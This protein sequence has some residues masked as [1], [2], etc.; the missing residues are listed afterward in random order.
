M[1][2]PSLSTLAP[3]LILTIY[4]ML[5]EPS[6]ITALNS[7]SRNLNLNWK[8]HAAKISQ[9]VLFRSIPCYS[10]AVALV[11]VQER[12]KY[13]EKVEQHTYDA[14]LARNKALV[15]NAAS[16]ALAERLVRNLISARDLK[17]GELVEL[18]G[19]FMIPDLVCQRR[20]HR[21]HSSISAPFIRTYYLLWQAAVLAQDRKAF[22]AFLTGL[23]W[24]HL[25]QMDL[26]D[27][28]VSRGLDWS[29]RVRLGMISIMQLKPVHPSRRID[30]GWCGDF[31]WGV[32]GWFVRNELWGRGESHKIYLKWTYEESYL[33]FDR[34]VVL[35][36]GT[37]LGVKEHWY[38]P[39]QPMRVFD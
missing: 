5:E 34:D 4:E 19:F 33:N 23:H 20:K 8:I 16:V 3:K 35:W 36:F 21:F 39:T 27:K 18:E 26:V 22:I 28:Y 38:D 11:K 31:G 32:L 30:N 29:S 10:N 6:S 17:N 37:R 24:E 2:P 12:Y 7:T 9:A 14:I 13:S 1:A 15:S 25:V